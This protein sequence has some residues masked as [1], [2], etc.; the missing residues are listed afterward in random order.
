MPVLCSAAQL[1][2]VLLGVI[3][4]GLSHTLHAQ[5]STNA[6]PASVGMTLTAIPLSDLPSGGTLS[7]LLETIV[8]EVISDRI[9]GGGLSVGSAARIGARGSP[10]SQTAF[11]LGELDLTDAGASGRSLLFLDPSMF[12]SVDVSTA[13]LSSARAAPGVSIRA[14]LIRPT[15]RWHGQVE[16]SFAP[17]SRTPPE[18]P[19]PPI[20]ALR[21]WGRVA[22]H[23]S[24]PLVRDRLSIA[25]GAVINDATGFER[26][27]PTALQ[28]GEKSTFVN[29]LFTPSTSTQLS[30]AIVG[31]I[32]R[33]PFDG[34]LWFGQ[35]DA[36]E[37]LSDFVIDSTWIRRLSRIEWTAV[38]GYV[39][40]D[41]QPE[42]VDVPVL[43]LDSIRD[44]PVMSAVAQSGLHQRWS[45]AVR[46]KGT[47]ETANRWLRGAQ[48]GAEVNGVSA[49]EDPIQ[50]FDVAETVEGTP[51]RLW[52]FSPESSG[53]QRH[54]T[55]VIVYGAES[56]E[57]TPW[58]TIDIGVRGE[59]VHA[60]VTGGDSFQ[61]NDWFPRV[62][63]RWDIVPPKRLTAF[64][65]VNR[66]GYRPTLESLAYGDP[67]APRASV[68]RWDDSNGDG[69]MNDG[70]VGP[71]ISRVGGAPEISRIDSGL[72]RPYLDELV[73][74]FDMRPF[75][76]WTIRL[77]GLT[78]EEQHLLAGVNTGAPA[79]AYSVIN[80]PDAGNDWIDPSDDR[81]LPLYSRKP[82]TFGADRYVLTNPAGFHTTF[83]GV[84]LSARHTGERL[85][86]VAGG[87]AG[88]ASGPAI[89]RGFEALENDR[90]IQ[91]DLFLNPNAATFANGRYFGDR[92]YTI[93][94]A[95]TYRF[96]HEIR[97]GVAARYQ[98]GQPFA[99][100]VIAPALAQG[101]E[102]VRG[103][104]NGRNRFTYTLTVDA[105]LQKQFVT[106]RGRVAVLLD[107]F[108]L[109]NMSNEVE[110]LVLT[111]RAFRQTTAVQPPRAV[112][113]GVRLTF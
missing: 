89:A 7:G 3:V 49:D 30:T 58:L 102:A 112:H 41:A 56:V 47:P 2:R 80:I 72:R 15:D 53:S 34:R 104:E 23:V 40:S 10:W 70:E 108:N 29:V 103:F 91:G 96:A 6:A 14:G 73:A 18:E 68:F 25:A 54:A 71:L 113:L 33:V 62:S 78:R 8:P 74:G 77:V 1:R 42:V 13:L 27:D 75:E 61:W 105:R 110:E 66:Y 51:A 87:T 11:Q 26:S 90:G 45:A 93:K 46:S 99:R 52:R 95:G 17:P 64:A 100:L 69:R 60:S 106:S 84:E 50:A 65:S 57:V 82:E 21:T 86:L 28:S 76:T 79:S 20:A 107:V 32:A 88:R 38:A 48:V 63:V 36:R 109:L 83:A 81:L 98:D 19:V 12:E 101:A 4:L 97:L 24:G 37:R 85:W 59:S 35:P 9:D 67:N 111:E 44:R 5:T 39:R 22:G 94:T 92:A 55:T 43:Y 16:G 31:C